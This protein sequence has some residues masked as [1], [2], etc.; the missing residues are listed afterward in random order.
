MPG[1]RPALRHAMRNG[2]LT[3]NDVIAGLGGQP[4]QR[5]EVGLAGVAVE[6]ATTVAPTSRPGHEVVPH[7]PAGGGEPE[8]A[9]AGPEV[10]VQRERLQVLEEDAAV[11]VDDRLGQAGGARRVQDVQRMVERRPARTRA[12]PA[13][14]TSSAQ[15]TAPS[16]AGRPDRGTGAR[17][18]AGRLGSAG[19]DRGHL[20]APVDRLGR[21][22]G[23]RRRPAGPSARSAAN[24]STTRGVPNSGAHDDHTAPRLA[25]ARKRD[26]VSGMLG[27]YAATRSPR[28]T[29]RR[30]RP[31]AAAARPASRSS[32][33]VRST[34][35]AGLRPRDDQ[36]GRR[37]RAGSRSACSA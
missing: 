28:P 35:G 37:R 11:A 3:P 2:A 19:P 16:G 8:E 27:R 12:G 13:R 31:A 29:P 17:T 18:V 20:G 33:A 23:S 25:V 26:E 7:H 22:S 6:A 36:R 14:P 5:V 9:V 30:C 34:G 1:R 15:G 21:R 10:V 4:P 32:P 24:R